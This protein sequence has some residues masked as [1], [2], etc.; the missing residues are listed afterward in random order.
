[1]PNERVRGFVQLFGTN[2]VT[3][4]AWALTLFLLLHKLGPQRFGFLATLWSISTIVAGGAD[5]G[6]SQALLREG[7][8]TPAIAR[9]LARQSWRLQ[10]ITSLLLGGMVSAAA[11]AALP[12]G[13]ISGKERALVIVLSIFTPFIDRLQT[14]FTVFSQIGGNYSVYAWIR[15]AYFLALLAAM[16]L[17]LYSS[18]D[19][20]T[21]AAIYFALTLLF[22]L[23]MSGATWRLLPE[24]G[25]QSAPLGLLLKSGIPFLA[26]AM[27]ALAYGRVEVSILGSWNRLAAAGAYHI[28]YQLILVAYSVS[29][30]FFTVVYPRLYKHLSNAQALLSDFRDTA[31][32]LSLLAWLAVPPLVLY[33]GP[34]LRLI[35]GTPLLPYAPLMQVLSLIILVAPAS[36]GLNFLLP[37]DMLRTRIACDTLGVLLTALFAG[38][39]A[40]SGH[41]LLAAIGALGGYAANVILSQFALRKRLTG[42]TGALLEEL[43]GAG[44]RAALA[45]AASWLLPLP[46]WLGIVAFVGLY[47]ALLVVTRHAA[48][49]RIL[50]WIADPST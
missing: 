2:V 18:D 32:W 16:S 37:L 33:P 17:A 21:I 47:L 23:L 4:V 36:A 26:I 29:G 40:L 39:A 48:A 6:T 22:S 15:S 31:R 34:I 3:K 7:S 5:L 30:M 45:A 20:V 19:L 9:N 12:G 14:L 13:I 44:W 27:L 50:R 11:W 10:I 46:W 49:K 35:G 28:I 25:G 38:L 8:R 1:M 43:A 24:K 41:V 42:C